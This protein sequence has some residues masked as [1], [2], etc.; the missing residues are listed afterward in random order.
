MKLSTGTY[1][2]NI[3]EVNPTLDS[4]HD[5]YQEL[6]AELLVSLFLHSDTKSYLT[7]LRSEHL[8]RISFCVIG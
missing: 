2:Q 6:P 3:R 4:C 7:A 1:I 5:I 8:D